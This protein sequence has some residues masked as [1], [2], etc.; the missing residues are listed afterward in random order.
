MKQFML[1]FLV[2]FIGSSFVSYGQDFS[3]K[4]IKF[5]NSFV[6]AVGEHNSKAILKHLEK[7]YRK[8]QLKFLNGQTNQFINELFGGNDLTTDDYVNIKYKDITRIEIAEVIPL[9]E[10]GYTY[11]FRIRDGKHDVL[12]S[13]HLA[14]NGKKY[15]FVGAVG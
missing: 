10:G 7:N 9:K 3:D 6:D 1:L 11:I 15:G 12:C 14:K 4:Q 13:L 2:L 5:A 8:E